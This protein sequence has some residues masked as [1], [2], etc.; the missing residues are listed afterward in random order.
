MVSTHSRPLNRTNNDPWAF[1]SR[2][3]DG[4]TFV[5]AILNLSEGL[6][7]ILLQCNRN[8]PKDE[9]E[10]KALAIAYQYT[11]L[12]IPPAVFEKCGRKLPSPPKRR[13]YTMLPWS[14]VRQQV[15]NFAR[16]RDVENKL[17]DKDG[18]HL[19]GSVSNP[20][21]HSVDRELALTMNIPTV[22]I[23]APSPDVN[24]LMVKARNLNAELDKE[25]RDRKKFERASKKAEHDLAEEKEDRRDA[26]DRAKD[27]QGVV[28]NQR[29]ELRE[30]RQQLREA[31]SYN[32]TA[33]RRAGHYASDGT[34]V[35]S[36]GTNEI[37]EEGT[38]LDPQN[39]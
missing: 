8:N 4:S 6:I 1:V 29:S 15:L 28:D 22:G 11:D 19:E 27:M 37:N 21:D 36:S 20:A 3:D 14:E 39:L 17:I 35:A 30:L 9:R 33:N 12:Q 24:E 31:R 10:A 23:V 5:T 32:G 34:P 18:R 26:E 38:P 16:Q 2:E 25:R 7:K 13:C